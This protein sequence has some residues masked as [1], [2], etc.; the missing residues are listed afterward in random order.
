MARPQKSI[1]IK[2]FEYLCGIM[3]TEEE[4]AG[5]FD[6]SIDTINR[7]CKRTYNLSFADVYKRKSANGK[8]SLR[9]YQFKLAENNATMAI[10]L[11]K[12]YLGQRDESEA[13]ERLIEAQI[14]KLDQTDSEIE[15]LSDIESRIYEE[16]DNSV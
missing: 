14:K 8:I 7:W 10:W 13:K 9:R 11:G 6:C 15:D 12:Q 5:A 2:Q 3:C 1:D 16:E 4:I